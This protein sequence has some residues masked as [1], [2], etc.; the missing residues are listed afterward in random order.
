MIVN[1]VNYNM[2]ENQQWYLSN[3]QKYVQHYSDITNDLLE[4]NFEGK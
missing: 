3:E 1:V 2:S 4:E